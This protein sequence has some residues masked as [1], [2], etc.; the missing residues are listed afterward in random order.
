LNIPA[1]LKYTNDHEWIK[2]D[3]NV[4][5][6]G[7]TD[8]AQG[9]LGDIVFVELP[10]IGIDTE[11]AAP[12]GTI[13]AVKAVSDLLAP[14]SGKIVDVNSA[15]EDDPTHINSDPYENGWIVKIEMSDSSQLDSLLSADAYNKLLEN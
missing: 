6:V 2:I 13:E 9:E 12:F 5:M 7:I 4:A 1:E 10:A 3:G 14:V 8:Y 11:R 15:L